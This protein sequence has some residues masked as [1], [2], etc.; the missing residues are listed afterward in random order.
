MGTSGHRLLIALTFIAG[1]ASGT[2][3][4]AGMGPRDAN[5][6]DGNLDSPDS[7][8]HGEDGGRDG[9]SGSCA[10]MECTAFQF[11][12]RGTCRDY[13]PCAGDG[14]CVEPGEVCH[15]RRCVPG[16][17]DIDGDGSPASEDCDETNPDRFPGNP[18]I[19]SAIDDDCD[20]MIDEGDPAVL[21]EF[22]PGGGICD[23]MHS[24]GC[25]V[26]TFD[27]DR[28]VS[29]CECAAMPA[30]DAGLTC[31]SAIDLGSLG[32]ASPTSMQVTGNVLP[33][34]REV[35]YRF[36]GVDSPDTA[37]DNYH[38]R[39]FML[40][41][42]DDTFEFTVFRGGGCSAAAECGD[43]G[44]VDYRWATDFRVATPDAMMF[45]G[46]CPCWSGTPVANVSQ[47][48]DDSSNYLVRVRRRA[49]TNLHCMSYTI[50]ISNGLYDTP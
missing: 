35:W 27:L 16:D 21:C 28:G 8:I 17:V 4:D 20:T 29:G 39:V 41:N 1:C 12:D 33:D 45:A 46:Q 47:C 19:C 44:F 3:P 26:G 23:A 48:S 31:D 9:G 2:I 30:V 14:T 25:P 42:P 24:C 43:S 22:Y 15:N 32:D 7:G 13:P 10:G 6:R 34:D 50:E 11:C 49:G 37:C 5:V 36:R 18:E 40:S 38:V